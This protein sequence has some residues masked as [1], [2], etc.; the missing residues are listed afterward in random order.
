MSNFLQ[1]EIDFLV[2]GTLE[3]IVKYFDDKENNRKAISKIQ[4]KDEEERSALH[5][6]CKNENINKGMIEYVI[7]KGVSV[8]GY[9]VNKKTAYHYLCKNMKSTREQL[10]Y[11]LSFGMIEINQQDKSKNT[12]L[13][14]LCKNKG[15]SYEKLEFVLAKGADINLKD[16]WSRTAFHWLLW[17]SE[18]ELRFVELMIK[19]KGDP[20]LTN[21]S[22]ENC[23][24]QI[25]L[26][27]PSKTEIIEYFF[28]NEQL[29]KTLLSSVK[30]Y[31][32]NL[33]YQK[34]DFFD[35]KIFES[36]FSQ[37]Q[38][39]YCYG[40]FPNK[41]IF[42]EFV[43]IIPKFNL[44]PIQLTRLKKGFLRGCKEKNLD[45]CY[46]FSILLHGDLKV[47]LLKKL[48]S[49]G[50][51]LQMKIADIES[52]NVLQYLFNYSR[53]LNIDVVKYL[54]PLF[55]IN[56]RDKSGCTI[57]FN[58]ATK[59]EPSLAIIKLLL[60]NKALIN[61]ENKKQR[62]PLMAYVS[63]Y[64]IDMEIVNLLFDSKANKKHIKQGNYQLLENVTTNIYCSTEMIDFLVE[65]GYKMNTFLNQKDTPLTNLIN[66]YILN[67]TSSFESLSQVIKHVIKLG[68]SIYPKLDGITEL[69]LFENYFIKCEKLNLELLEW[70]SHNG[71]DFNK[72]GK[73]GRNFLMNRCSQRGLDLLPDSSMIYKEIQ[74]LIKKTDDLNLLD[75]YGLC[76]LYMICTKKIISLDI[77]KA[78]IENGADPNIKD[79]YKS[80]LVALVTYHGTVEMVQYLIKH[81]AKILIH[82]Y[83]HESK[84]SV[85]KSLISL[86]CQNRQ[87]NAKVINY[88]ID[89][90]LERNNG[91]YFDKCPISKLIQSDNSKITLIKKLLELSKSRHN[92][93]YIASYALYMTS[94]A[95]HPQEMIPLL[96]KYGAN[97]NF[98]FTNLLFNTP[99]T[100][101]LRESNVSFENIKFLLK[102]Q[103][104]DFDS[105]FY[106]QDTYVHLLFQRNNR[107]HTFEIL[108]LFDKYGAN[109]H[110][111]N[112]FGQSVL[113]SATYHLDPDLESIYY[114]IEKGLDL[115]LKE[116]NWGKTPFHFFIKIAGLTIGRYEKKNGIVY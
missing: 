85:K 33:F 14:W 39:E 105:Q 92:I 90:S 97:I 81:G 80:P 35:R 103:Q 79:P 11:L 40:V 24:Y 67:H 95:K 66:L 13:R 65:H 47:E 87:P 12:G 114:L 91:K 16:T 70:L 86:A 107:A 68:A 32:T 63:N 69:S 55:D 106:N 43:E 101:L 31:E 58:E 108:K 89:L 60:K 46:V 22:G 113:H 102:E 21:E 88:L 10:E 110:S 78:F 82:D 76:A 104:L 71:L 5:L 84:G 41:N 30:G 116:N 52:F 48:E 94:Y 28:K 19:Y 2:K 109:F 57:L 75:R 4:G 96:V 112:K 38:Q 18:V 6:V 50:F 83:R 44:P 73:W 93:D 37:E 61:I 56:K 53:N 74:F 49:F 98:K 115:N 15:L 8:G 59:K 100:N 25:A 51:D 77:L 17:N 20:F 34:L 42:L 1:S 64:P 72:V 29:K 3:E 9:D 36:F 111:L 23:L 45:L 7:K 26:C 62:T 54:V 27:Q 99:F